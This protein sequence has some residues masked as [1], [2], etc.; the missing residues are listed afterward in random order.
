MSE[1]KVVLAA[2]DEV[3]VYSENGC[4]YIMQSSDVRAET[5]MIQVPLQ[6]LPTLIAALQRIEA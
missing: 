6:Y 4:L 1:E 5:D 2:V 3:K